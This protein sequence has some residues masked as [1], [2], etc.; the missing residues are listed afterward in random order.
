LD[1]C[2]KGK[3]SPAIAD[4]VPSADPEARPAACPCV[5]AGLLADRSRPEE[6]APPSRP[7][8]EKGRPGRSPQ[9]KALTIKAISQAA[10]RA[11]PTMIIARIRVSRRPRSATNTGRSGKREAAGDPVASIK[12]VAWAS[13]IT[14]L[15][16]DTFTRHKR[17]C[18]REVRAKSATL[19]ARDRQEREAR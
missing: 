9:P 16:E 8:V 3:E 5:G 11:E 7:V 17:S 19:L 12:S 10:D 14:L 18:A 15:A 1:P 4:D 2:D 6:T 13:T